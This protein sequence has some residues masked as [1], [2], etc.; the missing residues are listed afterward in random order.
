MIQNPENTF[1]TFE[2]E[3]V[4]AA[5]ESQEKMIKELSRTP[6]E[7][8]SARRLVA[9]FVFTLLLIATLYFFIM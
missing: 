8:K 4:S 6:A 7:Q 3:T 2:D 1:V 5:V 9:F